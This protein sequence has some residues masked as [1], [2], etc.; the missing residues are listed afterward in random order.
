MEFLEISIYS[1]MASADSDHFTSS[2]LIWIPFISFSY[3]ITLANMA[4]NTILKENEESVQ[5][6]LVPNLRGEAFSVWL[7]SIML[8]VG[9]SYMAVM[10]R[11]VPTLPT[12]WEIFFNH[13]QMLNIVK[14]F[15]R[16]CWDDHILILHFVSLT[17]L[18]YRIG[19]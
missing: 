3:L 9:L 1:I 4:S 7:W 19:L 12:F 18:V 14:C 17:S 2:F 5:L 8:R 15:F 13:K 6:C 10:L 16:I 11:C